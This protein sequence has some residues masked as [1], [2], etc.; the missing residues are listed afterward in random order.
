M[1]SMPR[2]LDIIIHEDLVERVKAGDKCEFIG[3][4]IVVPDVS[5]LSLPGTKPYHLIS[6]RKQTGDFFWKRV[7]RL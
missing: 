6:D 5:Q 7:W 1:G 3:T 4:L 2:T